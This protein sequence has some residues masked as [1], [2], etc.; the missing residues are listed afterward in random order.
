VSCVGNACVIKTP[1]KLGAA[2]DDKVI[3]PLGTECIGSPSTIC[4]AQKSPTCP[5]ATDAEC[6]GLCRNSVC[7]NANTVPLGANCTETDDC[8]DGAYCNATMQCESNCD[9]VCAADEVCMGGNAMQSMCY[10]NCD[11]GTYLNKTANMCMTWKGDGA[12]CIGDEDEECGIMLSCN[13]NMKCGAP[14]NSA[15]VGQ[16]CGRMNPDPNQP[17]FELTALCTPSSIFCN[18]KSMMCETPTLTKGANCTDMGSCAGGLV[19]TPNLMSMSGMAT[20]QDS[21]SGTACTMDT[22]CNNGTLA[23]KCTSTTASVCT[24]ILSGYEGYP[25][26]MATFNGMQSCFANAN[27]PAGCSAAMDNAMSM[28]TPAAAAALTDACKTA[29]ANLYCCLRCKDTSNYMADLWSGINNDVFKLSCNPNK[30]TIGS[31]VCT[32]HSSDLA[33]ITCK[34][35]TLVAQAI[36]IVVFALAF[37][38]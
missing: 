8:V 4:Q 24:P 25:A 13:D 19:C 30:I 33:P 18:S 14:F 34:A 26:L 32:P 6:N 15:T 35:S 2:C 36:S 7:T 16:T 9:S 37:L 23:C 38:W 27:I 3:C 11:F 20:C 12:T 5:C 31:P 10:K 28:Q 22:D 21:S 29:A 1:G 17:G